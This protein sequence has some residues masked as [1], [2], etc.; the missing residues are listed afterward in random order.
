MLRELLESPVARA[1]EGM[2]CDL[3]FGGG[4]QFLCL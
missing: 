2:S 3:A 1:D 4:A